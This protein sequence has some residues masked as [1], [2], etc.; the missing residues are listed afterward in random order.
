VVTLTA[1]LSGNKLMHKTPA[2]L[3]L[4]EA[5]ALTPLDGDRVVEALRDGDLW[6]RFVARPT[7]D[8]HE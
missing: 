8:P 1:H 3:T 7:S 4:G 2:P 5:P 6:V